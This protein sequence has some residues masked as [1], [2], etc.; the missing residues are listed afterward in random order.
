[1]ETGEPISEE[2]R[3]KK[4]WLLVFSTNEFASE[5]SANYIP[6]LKEIDPGFGFGVLEDQYDAVNNPPSDA[7]RI[8]L[9]RRDDGP[10]VLAE[11]SNL[12]GAV[13]CRE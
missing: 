8:N 12:P 11:L 1:M 4:G 6:K 7:L 10:A 2:Q 3:K 13:N 9:S 5:A